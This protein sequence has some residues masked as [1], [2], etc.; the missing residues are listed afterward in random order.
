MQDEPLKIVFIKIDQGFDMHILQREPAF[1]LP[2]G[3]IRAKDYKLF[4]KVF[5]RQGYLIE[6]IAAEKLQKAVI[7]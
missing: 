2:L 7:K 3:K 4:T 1:R 5:S 6:T